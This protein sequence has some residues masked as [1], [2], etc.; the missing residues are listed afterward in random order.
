MTTIERL[1]ADRLYVTRHPRF[2][3]SETSGPAGEVT[4]V[5]WHEPNG[6]LAKTPAGPTSLA[7]AVART[8]LELDDEREAAE[9]AARARRL[10]FEDEELRR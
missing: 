2:I 5:L 4:R 10:A 9:A 7:W 6:Q 1:L 8:C 3:G